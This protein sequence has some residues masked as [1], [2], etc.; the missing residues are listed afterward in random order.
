MTIAN[1]LKDKIKVI[2]KS[3]KEK[4]IANAPANEIKKKARSDAKQFILDNWNNIKSKYYFY[5]DSD[6]CKKFEVSLGFVKAVRKE[7]SIISRQ[8]RLI[9]ELLKLPTSKFYVNDMVDA[10]NDRVSYFTIVK[11]LQAYGVPYL[12]KNKND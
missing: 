12:R 6:V 10:L 1:I 4:K 11:C 7:N 3:I 2:D 9:S 5:Q 8:E